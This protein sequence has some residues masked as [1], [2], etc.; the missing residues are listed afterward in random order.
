[1]LERG[2]LRLYTQ[3]CGFVSIPWGLGPGLKVQSCRRYVGGGNL[4]DFFLF[5]NDYYHDYVIYLHLVCIHIMFIHYTSNISRLKRKISN[6]CLLPLSL[7]P[8]CWLMC[9]P[10]PVNCKLLEDK[11]KNSSLINYNNNHTSIISQ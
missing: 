4:R 5:N 1:M 6:S 3:S 11:S 10:D 7:R 9:L 8:L 2:E